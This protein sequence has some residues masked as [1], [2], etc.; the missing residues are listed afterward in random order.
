MKQEISAAF[1]YE[2]KFINVRGSKIHYIE[3]GSGDPILIVFLHGNPTSSYTSGETSFLT[4]VQTR[5]LHCTRSDWNGQ[6]RQTWYWLWMHSKILITMSKASWK[7]WDWKTS[8]W[9]FMTGD[10]AWAFIMPIF[11]EI[12]SLYDAPKLS[13]FSFQV[14][15]GL[16]MIRSPC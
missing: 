3:D 2:S 5:T 16:K 8:H 10:L 15:I 11:I 7:K 12:I 6:V 9:F 13:D 1:P 4:C 14:R